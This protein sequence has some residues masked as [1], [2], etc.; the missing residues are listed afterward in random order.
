MA[1][2]KTNVGGF[3]CMLTITGVVGETVTISKD[4]K[5]KSKTTDA[6]GVAVFR[7]LGTGK[8]TI[9]IVRSG[10]PITRVVTVTADY[11]VAIPLFTGT[12]NITYPAGSTCTC[13][14]GSTTLTAPDT[15]GAWTCIVPNT[16]TWTVAATDGAENASESVTI[17]TDG[18]VKNVELSW[19]TYLF[20]PNTDTT[21]VTGG[22]LLNGMTSVDSAGAQL[23]GSVTN[24][25]DRTITFNVGTVNKIDLTEFSTLVA[26]CKAANN[27]NEKLSSA[28]F[29]VASTRTGYAANGT[30]STMV[31]S[32]TF[33]NN[34]TTVTVDVSQLSGLY[35][36]TFVVG[37][38]NYQMGTLTVDEI[39]L[40]K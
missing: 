17:T 5:S 32:T 14:D 6:N 28:R 2:G 18:Q 23:V 34:T 21:N 37:L 15:S 19:H 7:G 26:T 20:K 4:G 39:K 27:N 33:D 13:T 30:T 8:W 36:V 31:A 38:R 40:M 24:A 1:I 29:A 10:I 11:S 16:G 25:Y 22:W 9:T 35:Y 3:G 12:I